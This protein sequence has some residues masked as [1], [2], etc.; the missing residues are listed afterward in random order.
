MG[1]IEY[2]YDEAYVPGAV[3]FNQNISCWNTGKL[4][5]I[6]RM[7]IDAT[8]FNHDLYLWNVSNVHDIRNIG[9][10]DIF[11]GCN[12]ASDTVFCFYDTHKSLYNKRL[13]TQ[14]VNVID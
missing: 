5:Y 13:K 14:H 11:D 9:K 1:R 12:I 10:D 4:A 2:F 6:Q 8:N 3:E 7:F